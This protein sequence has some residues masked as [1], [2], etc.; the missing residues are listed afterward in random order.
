M[1]SY[2]PT[3]SRADCP[4][5]SPGN[6]PTDAVCGAACPRVTLVPQPRTARPQPP[7]LA[8]WTPRLDVRRP[9]A[10]IAGG[11]RAIDNTQGCIS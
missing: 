11:S 4:N 7:P 8:K 3:G 5:G 10:E 6:H 2:W 9:Q 1:P